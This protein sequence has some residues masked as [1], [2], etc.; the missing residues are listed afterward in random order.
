[1][2]P[3]KYTRRGEDLSPPLA[4]DDPPPGTRSFAL[5]ALSEPL[6]DGGGNWVQWVLYD[7][8][9]EARALPEG[10][11]PDEDGVLADGSRHHENSWGELRYG[12]PNPPH[13]YTYRYTFTLYA[14]DTMLDLEAVE[15]AMREEGTLPWIGASQAV[16]LHG[17]EG[18][19]LAQG[20]LVGKSKAE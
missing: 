1:M 16:L 6:Q 3:T 2:I 9:A 13:K 17:V 12:G 5:I 19:V 4:W 15:A 8:P 14:L 7:I 11:A 20:E 18:H 10:V